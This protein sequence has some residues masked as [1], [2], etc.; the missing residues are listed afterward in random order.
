M[1]AAFEAGERE[2]FGKM[3]EVG[4]LEVLHLSSLVW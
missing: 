3:V 2:D 1:D 4:H